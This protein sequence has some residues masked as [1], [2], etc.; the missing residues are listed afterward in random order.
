MTAHEEQQERV[1]FIDA[2][3]GRGWW[4]ESPLSPELTRDSVFS[5]APRDLA[6]R[7]VGET[8][9]GHAI[10][11]ASWI[12]RYAVHW[13]LRGG[14]DQCFLH[15][16]FGCREVAMSTDDRAEDLRR[17]LA[18]QAYDGRIRGSGWWA[19]HASMVGARITCRTSTP[20]YIGF[21]PGPGAVD[22]LA[23]MS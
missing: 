6:A 10:E 9:D 1:V 16:V 4:N 11:P 14:G 12:V 7:L 20:R 5:V 22:I 3:V 17:Q 21:P 13:P 19:R 23:A 18:Q 8:P 2:N 15:G